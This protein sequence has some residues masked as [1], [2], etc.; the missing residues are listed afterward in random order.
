VSVITVQA[1][2]AGQRRPLVPAFEL[3]PQ[4]PRGDGESP[5]TLRDL[6]VRVVH[7]Q[8]AA[9]RERQLG[10]GFLR[11]LTADAIEQALPG[12]AIRSGGSELEQ[13]VDEGAAIATALQAFEDGI[14]YVLIDREQHHALDEQV[15]I[16][17]DSDILFLRLVP[18]AGG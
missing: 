7:E 4:V 2:A 15:Y 6:I 13:E 16:A 3:P 5:L 18:L 11:V 14:Y 12:G 9:F 1:K 8:V 17:E 10:N